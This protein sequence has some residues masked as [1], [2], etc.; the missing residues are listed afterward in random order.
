MLSENC[1]NLGERAICWTYLCICA[2]VSVNRRF[3]GFFHFAVSCFEY[4]DLLILNVFICRSVISRNIF[5]GFVL[6]PILIGYKSFEH[7]VTAQLIFILWTTIF[8]NDSYKTV[9]KC[10]NPLQESQYLVPSLSGKNLTDV[11]QHCLC[12]HQEFSW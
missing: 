5:G 10:V 3:K 11:W 4:L 12:D 6:H 1:N 7:T 8:E 2:F 9:V